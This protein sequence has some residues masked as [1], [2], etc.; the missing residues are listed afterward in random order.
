MAMKDEYI[1]AE[2]KIGDYFLSNSDSTYGI[3][4]LS[5]S[6]VTRITKSYI[7]MTL[8]YNN[9]DQTYPAMDP[10]FLPNDKKSLQYK[11]NNIDIFNMPDFVAGFKYKIAH[12]LEMKVNAGEMFM[13]SETF[14]ALDS[15]IIK[16]SIKSTFNE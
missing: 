10:I 7:Y 4:L 5:V 15:L 3:N 16:E 13:D 6:K 12:S 9:D 8:L 14:S 2:L 11:E 1:L